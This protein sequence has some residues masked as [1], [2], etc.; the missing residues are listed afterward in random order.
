MAG[1]V[2]KRIVTIEAVSGKV[3]TAVV[4]AWQRLDV[5][6]CGYC[7]SG[8]IMAAIDLLTQIKAPSD[9]WTAMRGREALKV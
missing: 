8:Q 4:A 7:Q 3:A 6:Q 1:D 9:T 2:G 5:V